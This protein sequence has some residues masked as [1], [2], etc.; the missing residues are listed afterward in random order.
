[1]NSQRLAERG[2]A[3]SLAFT[4]RF[5]P[6][7]IELVYTCL[8]D[9]CREPCFFKEPTFRLALVWAT[10]DLKIGERELQTRR[11]IG[12]QNNLGDTNAIID[13]QAIDSLGF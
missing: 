4:T 8:L 5:P 7:S 13:Y 12:P 3:E 10:P 9:L 6:T 1:M 11:G 2:I